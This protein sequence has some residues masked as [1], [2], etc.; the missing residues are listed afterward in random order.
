MVYKREISFKKKVTYQKV[1]Q[2]LN[3]SVFHSI[4]D[5]VAYRNIECVSLMCVIHVT[6]RSHLLIK[7]YVY[8]VWLC[9]CVYHK[10]RAN[11]SNG[12]RGMNQMIRWCVVRHLLSQLL[13]WPQ[14]QTHMYGSF[15]T[16]SLLRVQSPPLLL[17]SSIIVY[18]AFYNQ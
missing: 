3:V 10:R 6:P 4:S 8:C 17:L 7:I 14:F 12:K 18:F 16:I 15:G 11:T 2:E 1:K 13:I 5:G 9:V